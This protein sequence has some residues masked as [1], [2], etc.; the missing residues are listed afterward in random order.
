MIL[1][2]FISVTVAVFQH[3]VEEEPKP[4]DTGLF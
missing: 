2:N 3:S 1:C 4:A